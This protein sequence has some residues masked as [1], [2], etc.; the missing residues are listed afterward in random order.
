MTGPGRPGKAPGPARSAG[1]ETPWL[2]VGLLATRCCLLRWILK[3]LLDPQYLTP[4]EVEY[5]SV[6]RV[7]NINS[8]IEILVAVGRLLK[9]TAADCVLGLVYGGSF[10]FG[11]KVAQYAK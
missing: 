1:H 6:V 5:C 9:T 2:A 7:L 10:V 11:K 8:R 3:I 4:W